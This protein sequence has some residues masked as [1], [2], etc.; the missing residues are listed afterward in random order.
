MARMSFGDESPANAPCLY[1]PTYQEFSDEDSDEED[2]AV[3]GGPDDIAG[4]NAEGNSPEEGNDDTEE[5]APEEGEED[6]GAHDDESSVEYEFQD[7]VDAD[8]PTK[9]G[10]YVL[11][12]PE[13]RLPLSSMK[14]RKNPK[15]K[16]RKSSGSSGGSKKK[17]VKKARKER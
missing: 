17:D 15:R 10:N 6:D 16:A 5:N 9:D 8:D 11:T 2:A 14:R 4:Y 1:L 13:D 7:V 3:V 12:Q